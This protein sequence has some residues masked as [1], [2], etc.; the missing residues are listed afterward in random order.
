[1]ERRRPPIRRESNEVVVAQG[2]APETRWRSG[3]GRRRLAPP[4]SC[5]RRWRAARSPPRRSAARIGRQNSVLFV[6]VYDWKRYVQIHSHSHPEGFRPD[7]PHGCQPGKTPVC[8]YASLDKSARPA[9][10]RTKWVRTNRNNLA[11]LNGNLRLTI[12]AKCEPH[13]RCR[14]RL[15]TQSNGVQT[16]I[17]PYASLD[18]SARPAKRRT[19]EHINPLS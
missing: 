16:P 5:A 2:A 19:K 11:P 7:A 12:Y 1:M 3:A 6:P 15:K 9:K 17:C 4:S 10:R 18:G 14:S 13:K 8:P